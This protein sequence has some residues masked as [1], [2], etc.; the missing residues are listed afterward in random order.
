MSKSVLRH[1]GCL[2]ILVVLP[3]ATVAVQAAV[4]MGDLAIIA[5]QNNTATDPF[6]FVALRRIAAGEV[7]YFTDNGWTGTQFRGS[8]SFGGGFEGLMMWTANQDV[9]AGTVVRST[10]TSSAF[11]WTTSGTVPGAASGSFSRLNISQSGD[12]IY[13]FTAAA[14]NPLA[15]PTAHL[16]VLDDTGT[17]EAGTTGSSGALPTGAPGLTVI[18]PGGAGSIANTVALGTIRIGNFSGTRTASQWMDYFA[19]PSNWVFVSGTSELSGVPASLSVSAVPEPPEGI[20]VAAAGLAAVGWLVR[21]RT[22]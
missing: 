22:R 14:S 1:L 19:D 12:Q 4:V 11:T 21:R 13:A 2:P 15:N 20:L 6:A 8:A 9:A 3:T 10:A 7:V 5:R 18:P 17:F 16:F